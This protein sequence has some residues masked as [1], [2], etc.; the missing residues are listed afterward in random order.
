[1]Q[2]TALCHDIF[3]TRF[4]HDHM[5]KH[6]YY[7][8]VQGMIMYS[9]VKQNSDTYCNSCSTLVKAL[10]LSSTTLCILQVISQASVLKFSRYLD[11]GP[12]SDFLKFW[13]Q[14]SPARPVIKSD[15]LK[16][17]SSAISQSKLF[18]L[19]AL[20]SISNVLLSFFKRISKF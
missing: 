12:S 17:Y 9:V 8:L 14:K 10:P 1:M 15:F 11:R 19:F 4:G 3:A 13:N 18:K 6:I 20:A 2:I 7:F 5:F 16:G